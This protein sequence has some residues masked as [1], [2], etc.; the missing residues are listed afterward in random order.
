MTNSDINNLVAKQGIADAL[1][2]HSRGV[3]R[4]DTNLLGAAYHPGAT[5]DYGFFVGPAA[6]QDTPTADRRALSR[7]AGQPR[8]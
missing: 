3:D 4:A 8:R 7:S 1:A 5:V 6:D 2:M